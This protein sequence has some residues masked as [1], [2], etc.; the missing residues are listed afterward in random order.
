[1][2]IMNYMSANPNIAKGAI[3][4]MMTWES[5]DAGYKMDKAKTA[6]AWVR[7]NRDPLQFDY[8]GTF[9][10][11]SVEKPT[12]SART[13]VLT[14]EDRAALTKGEKYISNGKYYTKS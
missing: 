5:A 13:L 4:Q 6:L 14:P 7:A 9:Q 3:Q 2:A 10:R 12:T 1:R 8:E 11:P